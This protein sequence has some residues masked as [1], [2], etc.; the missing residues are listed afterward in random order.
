MQVVGEGVVGVIPEVG[1]NP[2]ESEVHLGQPQ[3]GVGVL[4]AVDSDVSSLSSM[5]L[6]EVG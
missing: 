3:G 4:L 2:A 5:R 6:D 1:F